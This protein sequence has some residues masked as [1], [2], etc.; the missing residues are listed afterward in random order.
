VLRIISALYGLLKPFDLI[1]TYRLEMQSRLNINGESL[2]SFW[3]GRIYEELYKNDDC[4]I[5]LSSEEYAKAVRK[6]LR[7]GDR[8]INIIFY[9]FGRGRR[10][11]VSTVAKKARGRM[12]RYILENKITDCEKCRD[13]EWEGFEYISELSDAE[14]YVFIQK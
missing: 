2:Y 10:K 5:N 7:Y 9:N 14:K 11:I 13:F 8:F 4:V 12:A 6:Y 1:Q 3:G